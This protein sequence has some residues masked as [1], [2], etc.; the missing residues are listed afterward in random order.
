[1]R[2]IS[3]FI[4]TIMSI[5]L[6][7]GTPV[8]AQE[9]NVSTIAPN[10]V[11]A[12]RDT[13]NYEK[14]V[15]I[16]EYD[17]LKSLENKDK[18]KT[19]MNISNITGELENKDKTKASIS[20]MRDELY[21][22]SK[23]KTEELKRLGY[24]DKQID[25]LRKFDGSDAQMRYLAAEL[26][27]NLNLSNLRYT[28]SETICNAYMSWKWSNYPTV[29][30]TDGVAIAWNKDFNSN[31][32]KTYLNLYYVDVTNGATREETHSDYTDYTPGEGFIIKFP[33]TNVSYGIY[34]K[35]MRGSVK[36]ELYN[37]GKITSFEVCAKYAHT[38]IGVSPS[39][40]IPSGP[41]INI[42][43]N[44]TEMGF[45]KCE[46]RNGKIIN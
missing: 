28:T 22:R 13:L 29:D 32:R 10:I 24:S 30:L 43:F 46:V 31:K 2:K 37:Q 41:Q 39:I 38:N 35:A 5:G 36:T 14:T 26:S 40:A 8:C 21:D 27:F 6:L 7:V 44:A 19:E 25:V 20:N 1:M 42:G 23:L 9:K 15:I 11:Q 16:N 33:M 18:D 34:Y 17:V 12:H 4:A 45:D 3:A